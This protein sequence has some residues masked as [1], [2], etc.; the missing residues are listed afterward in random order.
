VV[1]GE[2]HPVPWSGLIPRR[3]G[4]IGCGPKGL[5]GLESLLTQIRRSDR[6]QGYEVVVFNKN[7]HFGCGDIYRPD[8]PDYLLT[9]FA[10][11]NISMWTKK[12]VVDRPLTLVE[13]AKG[14]PDLCLGPRDFAPRKVVGRYLQDGLRLLKKQLPPQAGLK[15]IMAEVVGVRKIGRRYELL[16]KPER[17][18]ESL[19]LFDDIL[20]ATGHPF[21]TTSPGPIADSFT[22]FVYPVGGRLAHIAPKSR[23]AMRGLGLTFID[24]VL[25]LSEGRGGGFVP[26]RSL[27]EYV[28]SGEEPLEIL[29]F[30]RSGIP[31]LPRPPL[32]PED[33]RE[34]HSFTST[35]L[36]AC[37]RQ[38]QIDFR[39]D[40]LPLVEADIKRQTGSDLQTLLTPLRLHARSVEKT[41]SEILSYLQRG[42]EAANHPGIHPWI[43][44]SS[45]WAWALP[46][47]RRLYEFGG[48]TP[49]SHQDFDQNFS[50]LFNR[51]SYGPPA[52]N[53]MKIVALAKAG[54]V[55]F[56]FSPSPQ[57]RWDDRSRLW[58]LKRGHGERQCQYLVDAR[59][60]KIGS[61]ANDNPLRRSLLDRGLARLFANRDAKTVY[62]PGC[63]E[64]D[65]D[66]RLLNRAGQREEITLTGTPTEGIVFD[67]D[68]LSRE[69]NDFVSKWASDLVGVGS[70]EVATPC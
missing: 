17:A 33:K 65:T 60:P 11:G 43:V 30:S 13:W 7:E 68:S 55:N 18:V 26:T 20:L 29:A 56:G 5:Y 16:T 35:N 40:I 10:A 15:L 4:I 57:L 67:N 6:A 32:L 54:I 31:M 64:I 1:V 2:L 44:A 66:G 58:S 8:Q 27:L 51:I 37:P 19:E 61:S 3:I 52:I 53:V 34:L 45:V 39:R 23:V 36:K 14:E 12:S 46:L 38:G 28:P 50:G 42:L 59:I 70:G 9:N 63:L 69:C 47:F 49:C 48:L 21:P 22:D 62:S 24:A 41:Q 25:G